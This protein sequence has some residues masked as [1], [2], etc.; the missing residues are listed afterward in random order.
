MKNISIIISLLF[1]LATLAMEDES[2]SASTKQALL[3]EQINSTAYSGLLP[4]ITGPG[5]MALF[6]L[7]SKK[8]DAKAFSHDGD[9]MEEGRPKHIHSFGTVAQV[10]FEPNLDMAQPLTGLF[11]SGAEHGLLRLS[12][13]EPP[14]GGN[15]KPGI[16]LKL[17]RNNYPAANILAMPSLDGQQN[18][19]LFFHDYRTELDCP[20][21][22][23]KT[24][25]LSYFFQGALKHLGQQ[26]GQIRALSCGDLAII[27]EAGEFCDEPN[28]PYGL[29]FEPT[30]EAY[31]LFT[32]DEGQDFRNVLEGQGENLPLFHVYA[33]MMRGDEECFSIGTIRATSPFIASK[34]GDQDLFFKHP[35]AHE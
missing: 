1:S 11:Q 18:A 26:N 17:F 4:A 20:A 12:L 15:Y 24:A 30:E 21:F 33:Y 13:A 22:S 14:H 5:F 29:L 2:Q 7:C 25:V 16:A 10:A 19:N 27:C 32:G 34:F 9:L 3:W 35:R 6:D 31:G 23:L 8:F 28:A